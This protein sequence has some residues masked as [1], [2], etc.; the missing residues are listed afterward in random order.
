MCGVVCLSLWWFIPQDG[1]VS[2][3]LPYYVTDL[4][5]TASRYAK[6]L[7]GVTPADVTTRGPVDAVSVQRPRRPKPSDLTLHRAT[8]RHLLP[9]P[10]T[11]SVCIFHRLFFQ[12]QDTNYQLGGGGTKQPP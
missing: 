12:V 4:F 6:V 5:I 3:T 9:S 8:L 1:C 11:C 10:L 2:N 7:E